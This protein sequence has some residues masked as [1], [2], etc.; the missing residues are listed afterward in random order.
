MSKIV[1]KVIEAYTKAH[2]N[3]SHI[4][5][6]HICTVIS[7]DIWA[8]DRNAW[9]TTWHIMNNYKLDEIHDL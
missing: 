6:V 2:D 4:T 1:L 9:Y 7:K 5:K 8:M 3:G